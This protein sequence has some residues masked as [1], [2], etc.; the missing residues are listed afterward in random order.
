MCGLPYYKIYLDQQENYYT[1]PEVARTEYSLAYKRLGAK[2]KRLHVKNCNGPF[3]SN[4]LL[5]KS[6]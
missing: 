3:F 5:S 1:N 6:F 4:I 2:K